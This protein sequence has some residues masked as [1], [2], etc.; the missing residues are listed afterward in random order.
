MSGPAIERIQ[1]SS[2]KEVIVTDS[3]E[4]PEDKKIDKIKVLSVDKI[5]SE[6]IRRVY[7]NESLS[8]L[9]EKKNS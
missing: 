2:F 6:A 4:L 1:N 3:I 7:N 5:L 9:F 8:Q